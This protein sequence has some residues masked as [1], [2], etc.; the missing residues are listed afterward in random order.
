MCIGDAHDVHVRV[1]HITCTCDVHRR[2]T[3]YVH[4]RCTVAV[5]M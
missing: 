3:C 2:C 5:H 1:F 4:T